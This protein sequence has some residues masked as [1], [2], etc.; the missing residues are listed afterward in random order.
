[1][2]AVI[3]AGGRGTRLQ[4]LGA[5]VPKPLMRVA[6]KP[7]LEHQIECLAREGVRNLILTV[8]YLGEQIQ[9]YFGDGSRLGVHIEYIRET[10]P[11]GT[12]GA[13]YYLK[14]ILKEDFF[15]IN[16][17]L[18]FD[19]DLGRFMAFHR[20][21]GAA[22]TLLTHPNDHPYDS[23]V[24][25]ADQNGRVDG[26]FTKEEE[27]GWYRNR[28]N[29][30]LH[31]L[32]PELLRGLEG[33]RKTDLDRDLLKPLLRTGGVY[34]YHSPEY[35]KDMGTPD[36]LAAVERD[37]QRG[38]VEQKSLR[39]RQRA[40]FLDRDGTLNRYVGFLRSIDDLT[41]L[42]GA[43]EAVRRINQAG[44]LAIVATNQ[45]VIARGE[46]T[47]KGLEEIHEKLETLLGYEGAYLDDI[48]VC[49]HHP[50]RGFP[51]ERPEYKMDC[52]CRKPKPGLLLQ[53]AEEYHIDLLQSWMIGDSDR[54][55][56]AGRAAGCKTI[57]LQEGFTLSDAAEKILEQ[58]RSV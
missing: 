27:R 17:D 50:D 31:I 38:L 47:W 29:A 32:S 3:T 21:H 45:P 51:G 58:E 9:S 20:S 15:L 35:V 36:R 54:D 40:V 10:E 43:A 28:V 41:L 19:V 16:G 39:R 56:A 23:A 24:I 48:F 55:I 22:A 8:G 12:A 46:L 33:P 34:A 5:D 49:P 14:D 30:G 6:G 7:V 57:R 2:W 25:A 42:E 44:F 1:M 37:I 13:L 4:S 53:A 11:L 18:I 26:W 52:G